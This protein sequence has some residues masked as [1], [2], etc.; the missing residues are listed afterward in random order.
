M[1]D[2]MDK[3]IDILSTNNLTLDADQYS[4]IKVLIKNVGANM[5]PDTVK[6]MDAE[7]ATD[8]NFTRYVRQLV[9]AITDQGAI[10]Y[11][12]PS[13]GAMEVQN[14]TETPGGISAIFV[15]LNVCEHVSSLHKTMRDGMSML[16]D[17]NIVSAGSVGGMISYGGPTRASLMAEQKEN[18]GAVIR[19]LR[20]ARTLESL[21]INMERWTES[22]YSTLETYFGRVRHRHQEEGIKVIEN[23]HMPGPILTDIAV[24]VWDNV[25][26]AGELQ[27]GH[28]KVSLYT[29]GRAIAMIEAIRNPTIRIGFGALF[30]HAVHVIESSM[31]ALK[32]VRDFVLASKTA[33]RESTS[34]MLDVDLDSI[35]AKF[36][37]K[38]R[39]INLDQVVY[40]EPTVV[41]TKNQRFAA[42]RRNETLA[43]VAELVLST[44]L[45][46]DEVVTLL[47]EFKAEERA[48]LLDQNG[49]FVCEISGGDQW[50]GIGPGALQVKPGPKPN[51]DMTNIWGSGFQGLRDFM[52]GMDDA[53]KWQ[54]VFMSTS[55]S[56][57]TDKANLLLVGPPGSGKS[58]L[59]R[60]IACAPGNIAV[61]ATGADFGTV[62]ANESKKNPKRL[63]EAA[64]G[65]HRESGRQVYVIVDELDDALKKDKQHG[66]LDLSLE[67]QTILDGLIAYPGVTFIG[68]T[69][70]PHRI[71]DAIMR[72]FSRVEVVGEMSQEDRENTLRYYVSHFLP[73][74]PDFEKDVPE[75][76][77]RLEGAVGDVI[78]KVADAVWLSV[79]RR[80]ISQHPETADKCLERVRELC[81]DGTDATDPNV[82]IAVRSFM[83]AENCMVTAE[84]MNQA[85]NS[86]LSNVAVQ[87]QI[88]TAKMTYMASR[89][90]LTP[91]I[92]EGKDEPATE[93]NDG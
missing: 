71:P 69:N 36:N 65:L 92:V 48:F 37:S 52:K 70:N 34:D 79:M 5:N 41:Q 24:T 8:K 33:L 84:D 77:D 31:P 72:R 58:Q 23:P 20:G 15:L 9:E 42:K 87:G 78:R 35:L 76:A 47:F 17:V 40:R 6:S 46:S 11:K 32:V 39:S 59:M 91:E 86:L 73:C 54:N 83:E 61:A 75:F 38:V 51:V 4:A 18:Q 49:F 85:L 57:S 29:H 56:G 3:L 19:F 12:K 27:R 10:K 30:R 55:P 26:K 2:Q 68:A 44:D 67:F 88:V 90:L 63:F 82:R 7:V 64:L 13:P 21:L 45:S 66:D 43:R 81:A 50:S 62:W 14:D 74:Y 60:A 22:V 93:N 1:T 80:F 53:R 28:D 89:V 16:L 25:D